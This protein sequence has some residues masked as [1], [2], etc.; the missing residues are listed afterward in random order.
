M[1]SF[2]LGA[3]YLTAL[4]EHYYL[5]AG[6]QAFPLVSTGDLVAQMIE[7]KDTPDDAEKLPLN[8]G[9]TLQMGMLGTLIGGFG[10]ATWLRWLESHVTV[11][12]VPQWIRGV[13]ATIAP[14]QLGQLNSISATDD[15]LVLVKATLDSCVW[16]P[17]ENTL[18]LVLTPLLEGAS[19]EEVSSLLNDNFLPVMQTELG[20]FFPYNLLAFSL[21]PPLLR[22]FSTGLASMCFSV[23]IS[24]TTHG[25][26]S[27]PQLA[28]VPFDI[29]AGPVHV[30]VHVPVDP[31]SAEGS[32]ASDR[33]RIL[34]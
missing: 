12:D 11:A 26:T 22:P 15:L 7:R 32:A 13:L 29:E 4:H 6:L 16:A 21:I 3:S 17:I 25:V 5:T 28:G 2:D 34:D 20:A 10:T 18:F 9:R 24:L 19:F 30:P 33:F 14:E 23:Y 27:A 1:M 8:L 31:V